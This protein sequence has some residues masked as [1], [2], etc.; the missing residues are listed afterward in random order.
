MR[1]LLVPL[2]GFAFACGGQAPTTPHPEPLLPESPP[3]LRLPPSVELP[4]RRYDLIPVGG[5]AVLLPE[6]NRSFDS[7]VQIAPASQAGF[8]ATGYMRPPYDLAIGSRWLHRITVGPV[9]EIAWE[10]ELAK[11][12]WRVNAVA[13]DEGGGFVASVSISTGPDLGGGEPLVKGGYLVHTDADGNVRDITSLG[14]LQAEWLDVTPD[15][16]RFVGREFDDQCR[17]VET[18]NPWIAGTVRD[19]QVD[20]VA[21]PLTWL[22]L[23][24]E[25]TQFFAP[26]VTAVAFTDSGD[27]FVAGKVSNGRA[28]IGQVEVE[29]PRSGYSFIVR[30]DAEGTAQWT[31]LLQVE[32]SSSPTGIG[33]LEDGGVAVSLG[34]G[35]LDTGRQVGSLEVFEGDGTPRW[36][37]WIEGERAASLGGVAVRRGAIVVAGYRTEVMVRAG[38]KREVR[39]GFVGRFDAAVGTSLGESEIPNESGSAAGIEPAGVA[40]DPAGNLAVAL[41]TLLPDGPLSMAGVHYF[42]APR[43]AA[44][45]R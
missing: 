32:N 37:T 3:D 5:S 43:Y 15:A 16:I 1:L 38:E 2:V 29:A 40:I 25:I 17:A 30:L 22:D 44:P 6:G 9:P 23:H 12:D 24:R 35:L 36:S 7:A 39:R 41:W 21:L 20:V 34:V 18:A 19:G 26:R 45:R 14:C 8:V 33:L 10:R 28:R 31:N 4:D 11:T 27:F 42:V 13:A